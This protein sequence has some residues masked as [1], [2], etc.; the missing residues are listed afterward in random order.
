MGAHRRVSAVGKGVVEFR[1]GEI[2]KDSKEDPYDF[3]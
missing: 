3:P 1:L 2:L